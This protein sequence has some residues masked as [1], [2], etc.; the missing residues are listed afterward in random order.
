MP[1]RWSRQERKRYLVQVAIGLLLG[2]AA[3][4]LLASEVRGD[5]V[6]QLLDPAYYRGEEDNLL[7]L[8]LTVAMTIPGA[9]SGGHIYANWKGM[10]EEDLRRGRKLGPVSRAASALSKWIP[11]WFFPFPLAVF[12]F[13]LLAGI[14]TVVPF[15]LYVLQ[16][17]LRSR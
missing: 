6:G 11:K 12:A 2:L 4:V 9:L 7:W 8:P 15:Y 5:Q 13:V 17:H 14:A 16:M 1:T 3:F 10:W